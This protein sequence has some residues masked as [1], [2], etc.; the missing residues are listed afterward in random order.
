M[1]LKS[2]SWALAICIVSPLLSQHN[3][4]VHH[5]ERDRLMDTGSLQ[6]FF[7]SG[8]FYGHSRAV[9][10]GTYNR[11]E[12]QDFHATGFGMGIGYETA[13]Y[14][15]LQVGISGFFIYNLYS[16]DLAIPDTASSQPNRYEVGLFDVENPTNHSDLDRLEDLYIKYSRTTWEL[17]LGKQHIRTPFI[18]PQDGRM[19]PTLVQGELL[20]FQPNS[21][22]LLEIGH[23]GEISPRSTVR[24]FPI[25]ES[26]GLYGV[27][28]NTLGK[29]SDYKGNMPESQVYY[30]GLTQKLG[31]RIQFSVW[32]QTV[33]EIFNTE[34]LELVFQLAQSEKGTL[35]AYAMGIAQ[36]VL[37]DGGNSDRAKAYMDPELGM[38]L[39]GSTRLE[40]GKPNGWKFQLNYTRMA[41]KGR[42]LMPREWGRDPFYT[43]LS[44]E[45]NEGYSDVHAFSAVLRYAH[46]ENP[47]SGSLGVGQYQ[48]PDAN[49]AL[50]NKYG[51]PSYCQTNFT[52]YYL[53]PEGFLKGFEIGWLG[54]YKKATG[55]TYQKTSYI[56]NK[57]D[58][59][60]HN[61]VI[62]YHF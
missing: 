59:F 60:H 57:V 27:G 32:N 3:P 47:W 6:H 52:L 9:S 5:T 41:D 62:N 23:V 54:V 61:L 35:K 38:S 4:Y 31:E 8:Q 10:M 18:N 13:P 37:G 21:R 55:E 1:S 15:R 40:Y 20:N 36:Q 12:L 16:S 42:Y 33:T 51:F 46:A 39:V 7:Q 44:R 17:K 24:W 19:R 58:V 53:F 14:K 49:D 29:R 25:A 48:L 43:F 11:G 26:F 34:L 50:R 22:T 2:F 28:R 56:L 30:V 45:R